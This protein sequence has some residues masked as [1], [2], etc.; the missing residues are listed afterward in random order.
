MDGTAMGS[1]GE[2]IDIDILGETKQDE[3]LDDQMDSKSKDAGPLMSDEIP[4]LNR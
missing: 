4:W 1:Y 3:Q 2:D